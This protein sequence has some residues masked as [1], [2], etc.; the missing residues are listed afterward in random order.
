MEKGLAAGV[1]TQAEV[2]EGTDAL[3]RGDTT[4]DDLLSYWEWRVK[5][6]GP[7]PVEATV[8]ALMV[9]PTSPRRSRSG[10]A[11][12]SGAPQVV[13]AEAATPCDR[14]SRSRASAREFV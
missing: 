9:E 11:A 3:A 4:E 2:D 1:L 5:Q 6:P 7:T 10:S 14:R 8:Q 13:I 12:A